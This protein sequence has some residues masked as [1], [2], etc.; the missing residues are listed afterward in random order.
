MCPCRVFNEWGF[1]V[2]VFFARY[3]GLK[4]SHISSGKKQKTKAP[5]RK[6]LDRGTSNTCA[7]IQDLISQKRRGQQLDFCAVN[8][9]VT[10]WRRNYLILVYARFWALK[11]T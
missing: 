10:A 8:A 7:K 9:K 1:L 11:L 4:G 2:L 6:R 5:I 3:L